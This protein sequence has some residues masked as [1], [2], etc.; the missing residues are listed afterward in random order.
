MP[1]CRDDTC[2]VVICPGMVKRFDE[3][4]LATLPKKTPPRNTDITGLRAPDRF[5]RAVLLG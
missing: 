2:C 1:G 3:R 4:W 5:R